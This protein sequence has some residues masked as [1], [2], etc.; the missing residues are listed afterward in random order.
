MYLKIGEEVIAIMKILVLAGGYDQI[1]F[2]NELKSYGHEIL[3]AD[4]SN[5]PP[6]KDFADKFYQI[7]TLD[8]EAILILALKENIELLTTACTD[9]A[10]LTVARVSEKLH[11]PCYISSEKALQVTNKYYMKQIFS[12][13]R[14]PSASYHLLDNEKNWR[15]QLGTITFPQVV[16][17]CDCNSSKGVIRVDSEDE[18]KTAVVVAFALSRSKKVIVEEFIAGDEISIDAWIDNEG[19]KVLSVSGTSKIQ[20]DKNE[21]TIFQSK[22]PVNCIDI[23]KKQIENIVLKIA[24]IFELNNCPLLVQAIISNDFVYVIEFSVRMGGGTK[25]KLVEYMSGVNIMR[26]YVKRVLGNVNQ[27]VRPVWRK[28]KIELDYVYAYNGTIKKIVGLSELKK[29]GII[30]DYFIYKSIGEKICKRSTSSDRVLGFLIMANSNKELEQIRHTVITQID[31]C[32][33]DKSIIYTRCY[34]I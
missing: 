1:E 25:Y 16:K 8:E 6:A 18:L 34:E 32:D 9:Q 10:L 29:E 14:I 28:Q 17:P 24:D 30:K 3:L 11:L 23:V 33:E 21:F 5:N 12:K 20:E 26:T 2:I 27:I 4:Y 13:F 7:S 15:V 19:A 31:I 22:Y